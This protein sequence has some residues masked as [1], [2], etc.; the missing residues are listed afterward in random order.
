E[1][2]TA[3]FSATLPPRIAKIADKHLRNP[4]RVLLAKEKTPAGTLPKVRQTAY[5]LT[6]AQK[7]AALGRVLDVEDPTLAVVFCRTRGEV[8]SLA[9]SLAGRGYRVEALH[10][11]MT[12]D[13]R[14]RV[15]KRTRGGNVDVLVATDVAARGLDI[16]QITH[17]VNFDVPES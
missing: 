1:R 2:Q 17:V 4:V 16:E 9:E 5:M 15:M 14:D 6:R 10:G 13:Q 7:V 11:G 3:L 12:Q 8:D